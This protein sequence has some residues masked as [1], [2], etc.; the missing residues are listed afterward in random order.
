MRVVAIRDSYFTV[1]PYGEITSVRAIYQGSVYT[2]I[3]RKF[4]PRPTKFVDDPNFYP[5]GVLYYELLEQSG[6]HAS[7]LFTELPE[8]EETVETEIEKQ[9]L[10]N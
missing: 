3:G 4:S 9:E 6:E 10:Q 5:H 7:T 2:V 8:E 1:M